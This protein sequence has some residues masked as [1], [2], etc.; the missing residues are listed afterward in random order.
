MSWVEQRKHGCRIQDYTQHGMRTLTLENRTLRVTV[1]PDKG[2]DIVELPGA[3]IMRRATS[4]PGLATRA[5]GARRSRGGRRL[6][7]CFCGRLRVWHSASA[8]LRPRP[9]C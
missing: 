7:G 2:A 4:D 1:L 8:V 3:F 6:T 5:S 9:G